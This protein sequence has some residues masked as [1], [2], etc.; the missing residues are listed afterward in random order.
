MPSAA[1]LSA[2]KRDTL[3]TTVFVEVIDTLVSDFDIID[4]LTQL[5]AH[6][7]ELL[8][9]AAAG[10]LLADDRGHLRVVGASTEQVQLLELFQIQN[11][12]GPCLDCYTTGQTVTA[13]DLNMA[14]PWPQF[15]AHSVA[16]GYPCVYAIPLRLNTTILGCLNLF[17][18][19]PH[20]LTTTDAA[21]ARALADL[22]SIAIV[23]HH[24]SFQPNTSSNRMRSAMNDRI[25]IEHAKGMIA[26]HN[27]IDMH[28]SFVMLRA[29]AQHI[30]RGLT[31]IANQVVSGELGVHE[32]ASH[33]GSLQYGLDPEQPYLTTRTSVEGHRQVVYL[34]GELDLHTRSICLQACLTNADSDVDVD[35]SALTFMDCAGYGALIAA[36]GA[37]EQQSR[38][39]TITNST[40]QPAHLLALLSPPTSSQRTMTEQQGAG[41]DHVRL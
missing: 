34:T 20:P 3:A 19:H 11:D 33:V 40:R 4:I 9:A 8:D 14:S 2:R 7:V 26:G 1:P 38:T 21:L 17:I 12:Q 30:N 32:I 28:E 39:L 22:A 37:L 16:V 6:C 13:I 18:T 24:A 41:G 35:I 36:R 23:Q 10:I 27:A 31:D 5:S 25:A 29:Y 15:A